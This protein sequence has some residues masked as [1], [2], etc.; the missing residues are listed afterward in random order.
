[1]TELN[2]APVAVKQ[3]LSFNEMRLEKEKENFIVLFINRFLSYV[4]R[5]TGNY[6]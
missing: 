6:K 3:D 1:M 4:I 2:F 5:K